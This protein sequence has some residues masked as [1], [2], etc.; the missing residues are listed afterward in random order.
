MNTQ[1]EYRSDYITDNHQ[2]KGVD[3]YVY[4]QRSESNLAGLRHAI[5]IVARKALTLTEVDYFVNDGMRTQAEQ[6]Y[7]YEHHA[8]QTLGGPHLYGIAIDV[9]AWVN[10]RINWGVPPDDA[11]YHKIARAF[12]RA[13][14]ELRIPVIWGGVWDIRLSMLGTNLADEMRAYKR[15]NGGHAFFDIGHFQLPNSDRIVYQEI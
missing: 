1:V 6:T 15:R 10:G 8:S 11:Y 14:I 9:L 13:S 7:A 12:Q 2:D 4:G 3:V 5:V